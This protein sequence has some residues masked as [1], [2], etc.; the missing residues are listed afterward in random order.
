VRYRKRCNVVHYLSKLVLYLANAAAAI[1]TAGEEAVEGALA[2]HAI[3]MLKMKQAKARGRMGG[4]WMEGGDGLVRS[5]IK[6]HGK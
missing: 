2:L 1:R 4:G 5:V 6:Y 3:A